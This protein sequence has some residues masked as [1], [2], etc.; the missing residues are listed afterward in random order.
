LA[1]VLSLALP[2]FGLILLG[3]ISGKFIKHPESGLL[4]MNFFIVYIALPCLFFK[5]ISAAPFEQLSNWPFVI[6]TTASTALMFGSAFT[7]GMFTMKGDNRAAAIQAVIGAYANIGYMG[8]GLTLAV[9]G[10][11]AIIPTALIFVFD[12]IL[13]FSAVPIL[14][15]VGSGHSS[16]VGKTVFCIVKRVITHP[17]NL[18][19]AAAIFAAVLGFQP[20]DAIDTML[21]LLKNAAAPCALFTLGVTVALRKFEGIS[22]ELPWLLAIKL[23]LHPM[24]AW[25]IVSAV[26]DFGRVWT[27]TAVLMAAL[28]PAL[29]VFVLANQYK[30]YI[31]RA[32]SAILAGTALSVFTVTA[33]LYVIAQDLVPYRF[34]LFGS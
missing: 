7:V 15:E 32:S 34:P 24:A 30:V 27:L 19:T 16:S 11:D 26:G 13:H 33:L 17:F 18:A 28:P 23:V 9:L 25:I 14:M 8:P 3:Y 1:Q 5:L 21:V 22:P 2:F 29:N 4:W 12:T 6:A 31:E 20:P 10:P